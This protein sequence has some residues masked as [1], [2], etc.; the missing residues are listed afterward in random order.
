MHNGGND[1]AANRTLQI[2]FSTF[3]DFPSASQ[4]GFRVNNNGAL[5]ASLGS[6]NTAVHL[7]L[8]KFNLSTTV[9]ADSITVWNNPS[10]VSL[11]TD[12]AGGVTMSGFNFAA[13]RLGIGHFSGTQV[14]VDELRI[15]NTLRDVL[16]NFSVLR[17]QRQRRLQF[18]RR[19]HHQP[20]HVPARHLCPR[21][22]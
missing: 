4:F 18:V 13:D 10:L 20:T 3:T 19:G 1:D 17:R 5:D 16:S 7:F 15:G 21:R 9:D 8:V 14:G 12:P 22:H 6:V 11:T 2:G